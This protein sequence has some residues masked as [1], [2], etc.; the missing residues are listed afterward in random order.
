[1]TWLIENSE[2]VSIMILENNVDD[3]E[4]HYLECS[5][6]DSQIYQCLEAWENNRHFQ[7]NSSKSFLPLRTH[8]T[9]NISICLFLSPW[10]EK[11]KK[12]SSSVLLPN[13][14]TGQKIWHLF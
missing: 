9:E 10:E 7:K 12:K 4:D 6:G 2:S 5:S 13:L 8:S 14:N 1:M 11:K 3:V